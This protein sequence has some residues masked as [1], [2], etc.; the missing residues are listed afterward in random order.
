MPQKMGHL[1]AVNPEFSGIS[2]SEASARRI[3]PA[4]L[5][6]SWMNPGWFVDRM[7][8]ETV[9]AHATGLVP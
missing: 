1:S 9:Q 2:E 6:L 4:T 8:V 7:H 5:V 3:G